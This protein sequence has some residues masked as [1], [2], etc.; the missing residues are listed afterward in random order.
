MKK[1]LLTLVVLLALSTSPILAQTWYSDSDANETYTYKN[2]TSASITFKNQSAYT[3]TLKI[4][5]YYGGVYRTVTLGPY[6][7]NTVYF[8]KSSSYKLKI[9]AVKN[10][11]ASYHDG[12]EFSVT[13]TALEWT[14]GTM[15]FSLSSYGEGLGPRISAKEFESNY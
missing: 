2:Q 10:G 13:C 8:D 11:T 6:S 4:M 12:G 3:M 14:E 15:T 1:N 5:K 9:K 7:N